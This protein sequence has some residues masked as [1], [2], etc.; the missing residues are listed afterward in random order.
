M[1]RYLQVGLLPAYEGEW[2]VLFLIFLYCRL[3]R[4]NLRRR[5]RQEVLRE[6]EWRRR[7]ADCEFFPYLALSEVKDVQLVDTESCIWLRYSDTFSH[8]DST[9][10]TSSDCFMG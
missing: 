4:G 7:F 6:V 1:A 9:D 2:R 5:Y 3:M 10:C 8:T